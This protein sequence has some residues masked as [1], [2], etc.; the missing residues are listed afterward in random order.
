[1]PREKP[2]WIKERNKKGLEKYNEEVLAN[3]NEF[4]RH[5]LEEE[6]DNVADLFNGIAL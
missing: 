4:D 5:V 3:K 1:M 6:I 2:Y